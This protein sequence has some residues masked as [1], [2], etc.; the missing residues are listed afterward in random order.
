ME[1]STEYIKRNFNPLVLAYMGDSYYETLARE[2]VIGNGDCVVSKLNESI[3]SIITAISQSK[4]IGIIIPILNDTELWFYKHG[5]NA[6]NTHHAKSADAVE[7]RRA[8]GLECLYGYLYLS[9]QHTRAREL[10]LYALNEMEQ[11]RS[12]NDG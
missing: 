6:R 12:V 4:I 10:L 8:T 5:R 1:K 11:Q 9:G 7:Y 3:K 2:Y